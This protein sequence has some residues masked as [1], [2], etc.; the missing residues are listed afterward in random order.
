MY[1]KSADVYQLYVI[2]GQTGDIT[3]EGIRSFVL[4]LIYEVVFIGYS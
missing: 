2:A 1:H 3:A 4:V